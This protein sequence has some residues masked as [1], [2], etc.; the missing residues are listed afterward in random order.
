[1]D[2]SALKISTQKFY[3]GYAETYVKNRAAKPDEALGKFSAFLGGGSL[4]KYILDVGCG[5]GRDMKALQSVGYKVVGVD[6]SQSMCA[7]THARGMAVARAD[8]EYLPFVSKPTFRGIW[9][10]NSLLHVGKVFVPMILIRFYLMLYPGGVL[11]LGLKEGRDEEI[12]STDLGITLNSLWEQK[13]I[14]TL[15]RRT[16]FKILESQCAKS[17]L[18]QNPYYAMNIFAKKY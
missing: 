11:F 3:D 16:G 13:E 2:Y 4:A 8:F 9:A 14:K 1:M 18:P 10:R 12:K 5:G 15:L 7:I 6:F 17:G